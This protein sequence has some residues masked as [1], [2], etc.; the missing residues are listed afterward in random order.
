[1]MN[2][3]HQKVQRQKHGLVRQKIINVEQEPVE[4]IL[5]DRP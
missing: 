1:M 2:P 5:Q 4:C 3:M